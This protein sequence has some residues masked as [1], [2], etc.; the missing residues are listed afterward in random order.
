V[1]EAAQV[2]HGDADR[3]GGEGAG[4]DS[5]FQDAGKEARKDGDDVEA[6]LLEG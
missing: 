4:D 3:S 1:G 6:H 5:V 2:V